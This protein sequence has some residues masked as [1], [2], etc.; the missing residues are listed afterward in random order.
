MSIQA[1]TMDDIQRL[2]LQQIFE[3]GQRVQPRGTWVQEITGISFQLLQPRA[4]LIY[5]PGRKYSLT[6]AVGEL[7]WYLRGSDQTDIIS[8]YNTRHRAFSDNE[9]TLYGAYGTRLFSPTLTGVIQWDA[10][11]SLFRVD[12]DTRQAVLHLH[13]PSDLQAVSRDIPCTCSMQFLIRHNKLEC[14]VV[15]RSNDI[16]WGTPYDVFSFTMLQEIMAKQLG[17]EAGTY[18]HV[19]G[20]L[21]LY[22][23]HRVLA[24]QIL[25][26]STCTTFV[27]PAMPDHPWQ[28]IYELLETE[29]QLRVSGSA[30]TWPTHPYW[31]DFARI[32]EG[33]VAWRKNNEQ[34][35]DHIL[36][37]LHPR[38]AKLLRQ[39]AQ[40]IS[41]RV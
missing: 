20:S 27:M 11:L 37:T 26:E 18:T 16:I 4:R 22:D 25:E 6:F 15:M 31:M 28:G 19:V 21:H 3:R 34:Q 29:E 13:L 35:L 41:S 32:L 5:S 9:T 39:Q 38:Y 24:E 2:I 17:I 30:L 36:H 1:E 33:H 23:R 7:L 40:R 12:R 10:I 8:F 14:M